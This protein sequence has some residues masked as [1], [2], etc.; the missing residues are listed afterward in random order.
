MWAP[1]LGVRVCGPPRKYSGCQLYCSTRS[2]LHP[3]ANPFPPCNPPHPLSLRLC[4]P[5]SASD[6][7]KVTC[8]ATLCV[9]PLCLP[10]QATPV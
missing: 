7:S 10:L 6:H 2:T 3:T 1:V 5:L 4:M 9:P 8:T